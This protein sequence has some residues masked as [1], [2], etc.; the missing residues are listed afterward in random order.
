LAKPEGVPV[1]PAVLSWAIAESG[2]SLEEVAHKVGVSPVLLSEWAHEGTEQRPSLGQVKDLAAAL[3]RTP[4]TFLLPHPPDRPPVAAKF[5]NRGGRAS[6]TPEERRYLREAARL[7]RTASW[8]VREL[9][10][11]LPGV[12]VV[13]LNANAEAAAVEAREDFC[14]RAPA[15]TNV[16]PAAA[17]RSW[18]SALEDAGLLVFAFPMGLDGIAGFSLWDERA[19]VIAVN[20]ALNYQ[21][22]SFTLFHEYAHLLT[23]TSSLC[24]EA[25]GAKLGAPTDVAERWC[26]EFAAAAL[27]PWDAVAAFLRTRGYGP[28]D[29]VTDLAIP[30]AIALR[31]NTSWRAATLRLI[32]RQMAS[33]DL[34]REIPRIADA[35]ERRGGNRGDDEEPRNRLV[36]RGEQYGHRT[37]DLFMDAA[38]RNVLSRTD[39]LDYLDVPDTVLDR[40]RPH[41]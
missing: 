14:Q 38:E 22:R 40:P 37:I 25:D 3:K 20:T 2:Y 35:K 10:R 19:P 33:W 21:A 41:F 29:R 1:T 17:F 24:L 39:V 5:R 13:A 18:R 15:A 23:R 34:Y 30:K 12:P 16:T 26:E 6:P 36:I 11:P 4:A 9:G 8:L 28:T 27:L 32:E 7:Q 31:F